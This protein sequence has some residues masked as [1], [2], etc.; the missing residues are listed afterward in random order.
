MILRRSATYLTRRKFSEEARKAFVKRVAETPTTKHPRLTNDH[1]KSTMAVL[2]PLVEVKGRPSILLTK[3]SVHLRSHRGEVC[4]P[5]GRGE[6]GETPEQTA[7]RE[8]TEEIGLSEDNVEVWGLLRGV[9]T[10]QL[11]SSVTPM[12]GWIRE[13]T[14]LSNLTVNADEVQA[15]FSIPLDEIVRNVRCTRFIN[16]KLKYCLPVFPTTEFTVHFNAPNEYL[17][18]EQRVWGLSAVMLHQ[19]LTMIMPEKYNSDLK[20]KFY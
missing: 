12:V 16:P 1:E 3:R 6:A 7:L 10:Q 15:V 5:G 4:F 13:E 2:L 17:H 11:D 20:M 18:R 14:A 8:T 9:V 19:A